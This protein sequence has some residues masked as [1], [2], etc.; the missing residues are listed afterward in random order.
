MIK[1]TNTS[2]T[3]IIAILY[4]LRFEASKWVIGTNVRVR[5]RAMHIRIMGVTLLFENIGA[6][7]KIPIVLKKTKKNTA[8]WL[9]ENPNKSIIHFFDFYLRRMKIIIQL[10]R[11]NIPFNLPM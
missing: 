3:A 9:T 6:V 11:I 8:I 10:E 7:E 1:P 2:L 4:K 5:A